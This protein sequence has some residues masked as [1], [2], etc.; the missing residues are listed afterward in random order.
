MN[1]RRGAMAGEVWVYNTPAPAVAF[2]VALTSSR[3]GMGLQL[4]SRRE[5]VLATQNKRLHWEHLLAAA[6]AWRG[7]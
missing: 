3:C 1:V 6:Y 2:L 5:V 7:I 4:S